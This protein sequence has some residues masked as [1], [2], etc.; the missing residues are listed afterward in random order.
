MWLTDDVAVD[1]VGELAVGGGVGVGDVAEEGEQRGVAVVVVEV[2]V[3][4]VDRPVEEG[5]GEYEVVAYAGVVAA[6][7]LAE[8]P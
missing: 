5:E 6:V 1:Q 4:G 7:H 8:L 2:V 3:L